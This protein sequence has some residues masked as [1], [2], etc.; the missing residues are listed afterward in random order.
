[1]TRIN[2]D[3]HHSLTRILLPF[4]VMLFF[5]GEPCGSP[6]RLAL[7]ASNTQGGT[8][9]GRVVANIPDGRRVLPGVVVTLSG[10]RLGDRKIQSLSDMEGLFDFSGLIAG[11]Y[12]VTVEFSGF[13]K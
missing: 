12:L 4:L 3:R 10:E 11:E 2:E 8:I 7:A 1:M 5:A 13:K 6:Q 9:R